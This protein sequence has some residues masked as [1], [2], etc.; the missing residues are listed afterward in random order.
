MAISSNES[1]V[2]QTNELKVTNEKSGFLSSIISFF[3][4]LA[5]NI[6]ENSTF[7]IRSLLVFVVLSSKHIII[8]NEETLV[9][10][11]FIAFIVFSYNSLKESVKNS[12]N[13]RSLAIFN[14]LQNSVVLK[15][16]LYKEL[17]DEHK[18]QLSLNS[19]L[20]NIHDFSSTQLN[21]IDSQNQKLLPIV[22][23]QQLESKMKSLVQLQN[24]G[25][26]ALQNSV[27]KSFRGSVLE[28]Y[29]L[30]LSSLSQGKSGGQNIK[31]KL[32]QQA[33]KQLESTKSV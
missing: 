13:E 7:F 2:K 18:K 25:Q 14:E 5:Q 28:E 30:S 21:L 15:E 16:N 24:A 8:Y 32:I 6:S 4:K 10:I 11:S 19:I 29:N 20:K 3:V 26:E 23:L 33:L 31:Q 1:I 12:L 17:L 9:L 22:F 27:Y